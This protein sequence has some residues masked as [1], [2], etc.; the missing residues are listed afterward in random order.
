M[1]LNALHLF[2]DIVDAGSLSAAARRRKMSRANLSHR[3]KVLEDQLGVQ[4][5]QRT[6]KSMQ[7]TDTGAKIYEHG[8]RMLSEAAAVEELVSSAANAVAGHVGLSVS[9]GLGH[10]VLSDLI[11]AFKRQHPDVTLDVVFSN[12]IADLVEDGIDIAL[13][14]T[15]VPPR[16][17][18]ATVLADVEWVACAS[19]VYLQGRKRI[20]VLEDLQHVDIVCAS[21]IDAA[22][23]VKGR[24]QGGSRSVELDPV[25]RSENFLFLKQAILGGLGVG[26]LPRYMIRQELRDGVLTRLLEYYKLSLFGSKIFLITPQARHQSPAARALID[27]LKANLRPPENL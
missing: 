13:R 26:F 10:L 23:K 8:R 17:V 1:D 15:S 20:T 12:Q 9:A 19:P 21:A 25:L 11:V 6:T 5:L 18:N 24:Y 22:L 2:I 27:F 16:N 4:L 7:L 3:L 14:V